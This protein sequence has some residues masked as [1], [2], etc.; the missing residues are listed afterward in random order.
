MRLLQGMSTKDALQILYS[1]SPN[2]V[3]AGSA[4]ALYVLVSIGVTAVTV[5]TKSWYMLL[6]TL[7][8]LLE[9]AGEPWSTVC[10][11]IYKQLLCS[12]TK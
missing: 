4:V 7:T 11:C 9:L 5:K 2:Q 1:Y 8:A 12:R 3:A 6:V 10:V